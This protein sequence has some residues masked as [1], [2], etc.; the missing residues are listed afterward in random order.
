MMLYTN[1]RQVKVGAKALDYKV[2]IRLTSNQLKGSLD[3]EAKDEA[4]EKF[5]VSNSF[6]SADVNFFVKLFREA[7][8][9]KFTI[10]MEHA[11]TAKQ[12]K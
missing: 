4:I 8:A 11:E 6:G 7:R 5:F 12:T 2:R 9:N 3:S 1:L 10:I